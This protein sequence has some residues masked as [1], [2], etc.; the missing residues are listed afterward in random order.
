MRRGEIAES[1]AQAVVNLLVQIHDEVLL[2]MSS[3]EVSH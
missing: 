2:D 1:P 3:T